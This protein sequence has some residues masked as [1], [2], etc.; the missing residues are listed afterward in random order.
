MTGNDPAHYN[1]ATRLLLQTLHSPSADSHLRARRVRL[2]HHA[3]DPNAAMAHRPARR[4]ELLFDVL[5]GA[6]TKPSSRIN[7]FA[8]IVGPTQSRAVDRH[9]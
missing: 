9:G 7:G 5:I 3:D 8:P 6:G 2:R 4:T 1:S